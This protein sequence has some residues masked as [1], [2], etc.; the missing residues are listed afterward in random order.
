MNKIIFH[1]NEEGNTVTEDFYPVPAKKIVPSWFSNAKRYFID[2]DNIDKK[3]VHLKGLSFKGCPALLDVFV[4]GYL[5]VTPCDIIVSGKGNL[6]NIKVEEKFS[7]FCGDR[8]YTDEFPTPIGHN[9]RNF[10]WY[11]NWSVELEEGYSAIY[12]NP[13]NR[14][15]LPFTTVGGIIDSDKLISTG[16]ITFFIDENF[17]GVIPKGTPYMQIF[18]FKRE[19]WSMETIN[20]SLEEILSRES[21]SG[22]VLRVPEGGV[23]KKRFWSRKDYS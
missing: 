21:E 15:E 14:F 9:A 20:Y 10:F 5:L 22:K 8:G 7:R 16:H 13:L 2:D 19:S 1:S 11:P 4:S 6:K 23:Y 3:M 12:I 18:P 17:E